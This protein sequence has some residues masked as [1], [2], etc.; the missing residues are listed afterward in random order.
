MFVRKSQR[1]WITPALTSEII[2]DTSGS[3]RNLAFAIERDR[4]G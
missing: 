2:T 4:Q 1:L 3:V